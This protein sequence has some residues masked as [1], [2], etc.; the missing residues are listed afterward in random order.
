M[1]SID[2][3]IPHFVA[4]FSQSTSGEAEPTWSDKVRNRPDIVILPTNEI[5]VLVV[6]L[7]K[8]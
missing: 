4:L 2:F 5:L 1:E 6:A 8:V 7:K 3:L